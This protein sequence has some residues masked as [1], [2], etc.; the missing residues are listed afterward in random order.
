[1]RGVVESAPLWRGALFCLEGLRELAYWQE[2][3]KHGK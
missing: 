2:E 1:M 3:E